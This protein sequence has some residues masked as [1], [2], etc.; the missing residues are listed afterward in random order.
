MYVHSNTHGAS[1]VKVSSHVSLGLCGLSRNGKS[2]EG[3][4]RSGCRSSSSINRTFDGP[5]SYSSPSSSLI[6]ITCGLLISEPEDTEFRPAASPLSMS[7]SVVSSML[8]LTSSCRESPLSEMG[9]ED[10]IVS[11]VRDGVR[12]LIVTRLDR[13]SV[14]CVSLGSGVWGVAGSVSSFMV[15]ESARSSESVVGSSPRDDGVLLFTEAPDGEVRRRFRDVISLSSKGFGRVEQG[16]EE[17]A[18]SLGSRG[19]PACW[20]IWFVRIENDGMMLQLLGRAS[21]IGKPGSSCKVS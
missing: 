10:G 18:R 2:A 9:G 4:T 6:A 13:A 17:T 21:F 5:D 1:L 15:T 3:S 19:L 11:N 14:G 12:T 20:S 16:S 7:T 8:I